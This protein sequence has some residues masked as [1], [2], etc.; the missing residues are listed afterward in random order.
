MS[1][2]EQAWTV[3]QLARTIKGR[4]EEG[5]APVWVKGELVGVKRYPS[6]HWYFALRDEAAKVDCTMW[7]GAASRLTAPLEE[8]TEVFALG[9]PGV[10][11][12]RT[13][14]RFN[15]TR[16]MPAAGIGA[17]AQLLERTRKLLL[18][19]GLLDP[20]RKRPLPE[21]PARI[22]VVTSL[23]G[24][25][26]RDIITVASRRW[27]GVELLVVGAAVQGE[28]APGELV[29]ALATVNRLEGVDLCIVGR[30]GGG[31]ED[32]A[33]FN[34]EAVCRAIA[35]CRVPVISAVGH[36]VDVTLADLVA[37]LRAA[38]P[39]QAAEFALPDRREVLARFDALQGAI[40]TAMSTLVGRRLE[41]VDRTRDRIGNAMQRQI[42]RSERRISAAVAALPLALQKYT[43]RPR[44]RLVHL[45]GRLRPAMKRRLDRIDAGLATVAGRLDALSPLA[46]LG[47]GYAVPLDRNGKV[48][49]RIADFVPGT[50]FRLRVSDG[51]IAATTEQ[52]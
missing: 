17:A 9:S 42:Q 35:A 30:G 38:T 49:R 13:S 21:F 45:E 27:P 28:D 34:D 20:A 18:A 14:L 39:S 16:V 33:A 23:A 41:R 47:R 32:L 31:K 29:A 26:V 43:G 24:A 7:R 3:T 52:K 51:E 8:G 11:E 37:D 10:W 50:S 40:G 6:G 36:E 1:S 46:V 12:E 2:T 22:A 25:A 4:V 15:V 44:E 19:D 5:F 48:L